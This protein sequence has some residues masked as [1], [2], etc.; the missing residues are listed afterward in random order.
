MEQYAGEKKI[1]EKE[2]KLPVYFENDA[3]AAAFSELWCGPLNEIKVK[4]LLYILVVDG[5][6]TGL[7]INGELYVGSQ[8]GFGGFGH[9]CLEPKQIRANAICPGRVETPFVK[10]RIV[11]YP[12]PRKAYAEMSATQAVGRMKTPEEIAHAALYLASDEAAFVTGTAFE[13]D[14]GFAVGKQKMA[15]MTC[16][17]LHRRTFPTAAD[18]AEFPSPIWFWTWNRR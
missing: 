14:G 12:N 17:E 7:I 8:I 2:L 6:G 18:N 5:L 10:Q 3:N 15:A 4:T 13:I 1:L 9:M 11:E 16:A